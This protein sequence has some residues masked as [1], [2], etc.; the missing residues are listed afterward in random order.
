VGGGRWEEGG[1]RREVEEGGGRREEGD[2]TK[3]EATRRKQSKLTNHKRWLIATSRRNERDP[4]AIGQIS[5]AVTTKEV[6][7]FQK[8]IW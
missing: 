7:E 5:G 2:M 4:L 6:S 8:G 3:S 1:G